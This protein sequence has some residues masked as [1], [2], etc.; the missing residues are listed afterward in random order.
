LSFIDKYTQGK[1]RLLGA[2][3]TTSECRNSWFSLFM[4][5]L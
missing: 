5:E 4:S 3:G 1:C 2:A